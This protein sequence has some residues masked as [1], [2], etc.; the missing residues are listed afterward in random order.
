MYLGVQWHST[1]IDTIS[2][3]PSLIGST[4]PWLNVLLQGHL[5]QNLTSTSTHPS[6]HPPTHLFIHS[7]NHTPIHSSIHLSTI[8]PPAHPLKN[9]HKITEL[10]VLLTCPHLS[11]L[12]VSGQVPQSV[13]RILPAVWRGKEASLLHS[14]GMSR[15]CSP[16]P[17]GVHSS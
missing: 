13:W 7:C 5:K 8:R 16:P 2:H 10:L 6:L 17:R 4:T 1:L 15:A 11:S 14:Q 12:S 9:F 3:W